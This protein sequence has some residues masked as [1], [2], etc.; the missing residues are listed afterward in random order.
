GAKGGVY[1]RMFGSLFRVS[2]SRVARIYSPHG[3][4]LHYDAATPK[5]RTFFLLE[6]VMG[7]FT[8]AVIFVSAQEMQT[9]RQK[10]GEPRSAYR[11]IRNGLRDDDFEPVGTDPDAAD[12]LYVGMMRDLKGPDLFIDALAEAA[13]RTG[14]WLSAVMVGD[15]ADV[16]RYR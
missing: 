3:G 9:Y 7:S 12:F 1:S 15:G 4:S 11:L 6:R 13:A 16:A 2:R 8:D 10:V 5:G 14:R